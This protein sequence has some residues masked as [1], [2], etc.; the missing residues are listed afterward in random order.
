MKKFAEIIRARDWENQQI[1]GANKAAPHSPLNSFFSEEEALA[2]KDSAYKQS[3]NGEWK[4][5]L[6]SRPEAVPAESVE[7]QF[8]DSDWHCF[9]P[10]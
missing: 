4:F 1:I 7:A 9:H 3:L 10:A 6:F 5:S 2:G 8:D